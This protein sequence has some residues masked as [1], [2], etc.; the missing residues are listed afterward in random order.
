MWWEVMVSTSGSSKSALSFSVNCL[1]FHKIKTK[2][3]VLNPDLQVMTGR[4]DFLDKREKPKRNRTHVT[5]FKIVSA[6]RNWKQHAKQIAARAKFIN[7]KKYK[8]QKGIFIPSTILKYTR[9][10]LADAT[11]LTQCAKI[12]LVQSVRGYWRTYAEILV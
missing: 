8:R 11:E 6:V 9:L 1:D 2:N 5:P 3:C 12:L 10:I 4:L 7:E